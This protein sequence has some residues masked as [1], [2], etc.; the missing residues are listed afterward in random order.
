ML[1]CGLAAL[2]ASSARA[3]DR[4]EIQVYD[5][6]TAG[7]W[8]PGLELHLN[9]VFSGTTLPSADGAEPTSNVFHLTFEPHLGLGEWAELG[10]YLQTA[11][12]PGPDYDYAGVKLRVKLRYPEKLFGMLGLA[13]NFEV[14]DVPA[15]FEPNVWG[16]EMRLIADLRW[17]LL[18]FSLNAII[19]MDLQGALAGQ[20]QLSP[21]AKA[22][23]F[24][25]DHPGLAC[26][27]GLE[28][29][30]ALGPFKDFYGASEQFHS[31]YGVLDFMSDYVDLNIGLGYGWGAADPWVGKAILGFHPRA[32]APDG[33]IA[34][35]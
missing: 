12:T 13:V 5:S 8:V 17:R 6:E 20:P 2:S 16:L 25:W 28:Y 7:P 11:L 3:Q 32:T 19:G 15:V 23:V 10:A 33:T 26:A 22:S 27:A 18:Y 24:Y 4:F 9:Y 31:L 35:P 34:A 1:L 29:Y 30:G 21:A 14:S